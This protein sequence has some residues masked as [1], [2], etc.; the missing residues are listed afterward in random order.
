MVES[1]GG[2]EGLLGRGHA[3]KLTGT[4]EKNTSESL[5]KKFDI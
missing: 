4:R 1:D 5:K 3:Q 2:V